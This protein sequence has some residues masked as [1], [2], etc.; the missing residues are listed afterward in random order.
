MET[1]PSSEAS[2]ILL[3]RDGG[4]TETDRDCGT[5]SGDAGRWMG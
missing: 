5:V 1:E 2:T 4:G 3:D